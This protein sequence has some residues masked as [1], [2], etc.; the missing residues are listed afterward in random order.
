VGC[1]SCQDELRWDVQVE[2][3]V[4]QNKRAGLFWGWWLRVVGAAPVLRLRGRGAWGWRGYNGRSKSRGLR[5]DNYDTE[6]GLKEQ[7]T[8]SQAMFEFHMGHPCFFPQPLFFLASKQDA[9]KSRPKS[10]H[11]F[12]FF[13]SRKQSSPSCIF[14]SNLHGFG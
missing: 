6:T 5:G 8:L 13:F 12:F 4:W 3:Y 7:S 11:P 1:L 9:H 14:S 10:S 2:R